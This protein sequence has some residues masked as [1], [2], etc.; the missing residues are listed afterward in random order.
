MDKK[1]GV[2]QGKGVPIIGSKKEGQEIVNAIMSQ[3][4][5]VIENILTAIDGLERRVAVIEE[6]KQLFP[7]SI[8]VIIKKEEK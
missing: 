8:N 2:P 3:L 7:S 1:Q 4:S 6:V 5:P